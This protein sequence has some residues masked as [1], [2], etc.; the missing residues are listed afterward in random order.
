M[1][2]F[3]YVSRSSF[4]ITLILSS[5]YI[6]YYLFAIFF[7]QQFVFALYDNISRNAL[8]V[9]RRRSIFE[10]QIWHNALES[11]EHINNYI[12]HIVVRIFALKRSLSNIILFANNRDSLDIRMLFAN[13]NNAKREFKLDLRSRQFVSL[14]SLFFVFISLFFFFFMSTQFARQFERRRRRFIFFSLLFQIALSKDLN[15]NNVFDDN[16]NTNNNFRNIFKYKIFENKELLSL[17]STGFFSTLFIKR[18]QE[19]SY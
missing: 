4:S 10:I 5:L 18:R 7:T 14:V 1:F 15:S 3:V 12:V 6:L 8:F 13:K 9:V 17:L 2:R 16:V 11:N 19:R